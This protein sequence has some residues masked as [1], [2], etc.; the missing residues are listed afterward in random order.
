MHLIVSDVDGTLLMPGEKTIG[1]STAAAIDYV[2]SK[3][4]AFAVASGRSFTELRKLF[5]G[6]EDK[7]YF[8]A[9]DGAIGVYRGETLFSSP[10]SGFSGECFA[11]HGKYAAYLKCEKLPLIRAHMR[12]YDSHVMRIAD[13]SEIDV[14]V[15]KITD[16]APERKTE[17]CP[18]YRSREMTEY[19]CRGVNK[20]AAVKKL[21][22]IIG[23]GKENVISFGDGENDLELFEESGLSIAVAGAP[24]KVKRA[25]M[26]TAVSFFDEIRKQI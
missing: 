2:L 26:K 20:G 15:Y 10:V 6:W 8:I 5:A 12:H 25:A 18:V 11:A 1:I 13:F 21:C 3:G 22:K 7:I 14:P 19:V 9:S 16:F 17:L 24:P 4:A 23:V